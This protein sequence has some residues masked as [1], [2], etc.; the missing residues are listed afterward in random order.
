MICF[1][2]ARNTLWCSTPRDTIPV[3]FLNQSQMNNPVDIYE[4][5]VQVLAQEENEFHEFHVLP[6]EHNHILNWLF[7]YGK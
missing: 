5:T 7:S 1:K 2:R 4:R 3:Q 6:S